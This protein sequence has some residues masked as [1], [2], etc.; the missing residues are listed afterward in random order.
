ML[1]PRVFV[2]GLAVV[3]GVRSECDDPDASLCLVERLAEMEDVRRG[4]W[5]GITAKI[6]W[7]AQSHRIPA[8]GNRR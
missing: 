5:L 3:T 7:L 8:L 2:G 1:L 4:P 6:M